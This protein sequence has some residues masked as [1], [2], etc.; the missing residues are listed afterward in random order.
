MLERNDHTLVSFHSGTVQPYDTAS[1]LHNICFSRKY[2]YCC[3]ADLEEAPVGLGE[4]MAISVNKRL[5]EAN[6]KSDYL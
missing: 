1:L 3:I 4:H 2:N 5:Q 6:T